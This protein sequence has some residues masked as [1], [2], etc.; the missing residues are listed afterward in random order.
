MS[1]NWD[2]TKVKDRENFTDEQFQMLD[3]MIWFTMAVGMR[4]ITEDNAKEFH[5]R[6]QLIEKLHGALMGVGPS[7][8]FLKLEDVQMCIGLT[9]NAST[10]TRNQFTKIQTDRFYKER[11]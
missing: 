7:E 4:E 11:V 8:R 5:A 3:N 9:T 6:V 2:A 1:L 10:Y